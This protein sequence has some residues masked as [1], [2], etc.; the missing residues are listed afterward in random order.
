M[1]KET[2]GLSVYLRAVALGYSITIRGA[3][4]SAVVFS[5]IETAKENGLDPFLYLP[6]VFRDAPNGVHV[7]HM[8]L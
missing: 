8:F 4:S 5:L 1:H 7:E 3:K 2:T 6:R